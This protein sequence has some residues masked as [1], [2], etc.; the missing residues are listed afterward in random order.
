MMV[1][2]SA[3]RSRADT[4]YKSTMDGRGFLNPWSRLLRPIFQKYAALILMENLY[5]FLLPVLATFC[6]FRATTTTLLCWH[7]TLNP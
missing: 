2:D 1:K 7:S 5:V 4:T 6:L 3:I